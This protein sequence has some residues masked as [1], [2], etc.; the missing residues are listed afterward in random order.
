MKLLAVETSAVTAS[1]AFSDGAHITEE[2]ANNGLNHSRNLLPMIDSVLQKAGVSIDEIDAFLC[3]NGPGSFTGVRIG[4]ATVKGLAAACDKPCA[5]LSTLLSMAYGAPDGLLCCVMDARRGQFYNALFEKTGNRV[6]RLTEDSADA[7]ETV[8]SRLAGR[9][10]TLLGDGAEAFLPFAAGLSFTV[11]D[12]DERFQRASG[13]I[14]AAQNEPVSYV[15]SAD[16]LP[17]YLRK[18]QAERVKEENKK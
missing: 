6:T 18:P 1:V 14:F 10:F 9:S 2:F 3:T 11:P 12:G 8:V 15:S 16:L 17:G 5:G 13:V 4:V 7:G